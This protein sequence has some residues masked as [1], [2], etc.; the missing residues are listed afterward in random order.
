LQLF[1]R[2]L[3][4]FFGGTLLMQRNHGVVVFEYLNFLLMLLYLPH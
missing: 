3:W 1:L 2:F 4:L